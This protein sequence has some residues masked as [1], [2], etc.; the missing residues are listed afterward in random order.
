MPINP[1]NPP[2]FITNPEA[3][4]PVYVVGGSGG[5]ATGATGPTGPTGASGATG[6]TGATGASGP[7]YASYGSFYST[8]TQDVAV[9]GT[10]Q[11][12]TFDN[13]SGTADITLQTGTQITFANPGTYLMIASVITNDTVGGNAISYWCKQ[14]GTTVVDSATVC[15]QPI[16]GLFLDSSVNLIVGT[17]APN[18]Y[19]EWFFTGQ[20]TTN[21][22][23]ALP[24]GTVGATDPA[25]PSIIVTV[26]QI[27]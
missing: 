15:G 13:S 17:I 6:S 19:V 1:A 7:L 23:V 12:I 2:N 24:A 14:N 22:I 8:Q 27:A 4:I 20:A 16:G 9:A 18:E 21:Q 10:E 5:G 3:A 11:A 26:N 25:C